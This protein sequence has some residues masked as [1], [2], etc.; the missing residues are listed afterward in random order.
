LK[1]YC[2]AGVKSLRDKYQRE[3]NLLIEQN[4]VLKNDVRTMKVSVLSRLSLTFLHLS[5]PAAALGRKT[6]HDLKTLAS[7]SYGSKR[8]KKDGN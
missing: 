2:D 1:E 8:D 6:F 3:R 4:W 7:Q 5:G